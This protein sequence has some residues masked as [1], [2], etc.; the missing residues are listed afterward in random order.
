MA[1]LATYDPEVESRGA[2]RPSHVGE[3]SCPGRLPAR[4]AVGNAGD[5]PEHDLAMVSR[6]PITLAGRRRM[7]GAPCRRE[8]RRPVAAPSSSRDSR[9]LLM[10]ARGVTAQRDRT[11]AGRGFGGGAPARNEPRKVGAVMS[12]LPS[13]R[14][15]LRSWCLTAPL[16]GRHWFA[17]FR[18]SSTFVPSRRTTEPPPDISEEICGSM[19]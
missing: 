10:G 3:W 14:I 15:E 4:T 7:A 18:G 9:A 19:A 17:P 13:I 8:G 16:Q 6:K 5:Q 2:R 12:A 1:Q 11:H